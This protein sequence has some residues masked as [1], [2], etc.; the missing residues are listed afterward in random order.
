MSRAR[1]VLQLNNAQCWLSGLGSHR[2]QDLGDSENVWI[3]GKKDKDHDYKFDTEMKE[4]R[5]MQQELGDPTARRGGV[6]HG[7]TSSPTADRDPQLEPAR[8]LLSER[9]LLVVSWPDDVTER[10]LSVQPAADGADVAVFS[11]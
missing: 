2:W 10:G 4:Q 7:A 1:T 5:A 8:E 6:L 11:P 3:G 9:A